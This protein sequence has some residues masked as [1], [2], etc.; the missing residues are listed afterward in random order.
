MHVTL[1]CMTQLWVVESHWQYWEGLHMGPVNFAPIES[2]FL[3]I[4]VEVAPPALFLKAQGIKTC[5][6]AIFLA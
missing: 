6:P 3:R 2:R 4:V 1:D 5:S